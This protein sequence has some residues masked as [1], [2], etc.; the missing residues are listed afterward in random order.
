MNGGSTWRQFVIYSK[1]SIEALIIPPVLILLIPLIVSIGLAIARQRPW[2][3]DAWH[4]SYWLALTQLIYFPATIA[5]GVLFP[6]IAGW[7][8]PQSNIAGERWLNCIFYGSLATGVYW[9]YRMKEM[10]WFAA[11]LISLQQLVLSCAA[12]IAGMSV[13]GQ[14]L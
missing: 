6:A 4:W 7:P 12:F 3:S 14:W 8:S 11:S 10:R 1:W 13:S 2:R 5:I 9:I